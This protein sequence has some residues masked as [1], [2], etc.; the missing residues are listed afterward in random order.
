M[1]DVQT[2]ITEIRNQ[3]F[4]ED[5]RVKPELFGEVASDLGRGVCYTTRQAAECVQQPVARLLWR[6]Q[7][8]GNQAARDVRATGSPA[9]RRAKAALPKKSFGTTNIWCG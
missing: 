3:G 2:R 1:S 7:G 6:S 4:Y 8:A 9:R 5:G